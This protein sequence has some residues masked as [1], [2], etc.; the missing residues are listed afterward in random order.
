MGAGESGI[1]GP[2]KRGSAFRVARLVIPLG[3]ALGSLSVAGSTGMQSEAS[4]PSRLASTLNA[5]CVAPKTLGPKTLFVGVKG[6]V[7]QSVPLGRIDNFVPLSRKRAW[8]VYNF[9]LNESERPAVV[10]IVFLRSATSA[11]EAAMVTFMR[12][13]GSFSDVAEL[14]Q[15]IYPYAKSPTHPNPHSFT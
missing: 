2:V 12:Q 7:R 15:R 1:I 6:H 5:P 11:D 9:V 4:T 8:C 14:R 13:T 10:S 3:V